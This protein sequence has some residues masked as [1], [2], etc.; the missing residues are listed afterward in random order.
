MSEIATRH[1]HGAYETHYVGEEQHVSGWTGWI[2][3][4]GFLMILSGMFQAID[5]LVGIFRG[6][7]YL[8]SNNSNQLLLVQNV[9]TWG[10]INLIIGAI[11]VLGGF[12]LFTGSTW[13][14]V[15][16]VFLAMGAAIANL[17]AIALYPAW[18]IIA[19]TMSVL[20]MYAVIVHG[21]E[22]KEE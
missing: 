10:W 3:F 5:G 7:F 19:I 2:G 22:L 8:V 1:H 17:L 9:H 13:A 6:S 11:V 12:A 21:N 20:V 15:L 4:A 16:A 14:R 18:S